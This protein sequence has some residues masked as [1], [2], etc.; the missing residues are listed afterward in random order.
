VRAY[1][2]SV[3]FQMAAIS[4]A[5]LLPLFWEE[6]GMGKGAIGSLNS[7]GMAISLVGPFFF[8]WIGSRSDP[9]R[10]VALCFFG[11]AV[12]G[13]LMLLW[14]S[15]LGQG[16]LFGASQFL[17][18]GYLTLVPVG[19]LHLLGPR[20]GLDYGRYRRVGSTGFAVAVA[21]TGFLL[22]RLGNETILWASA[23]CALLAGLP[24]VNTIRIPTPR[25][26]GDSYT[27]VM[28]NA[29]IRWFLF[30]SLVLGTWQAAP[31]VFLQ[32]RMKE[33]GAATGLIGLVLAEGGI[34]A[35]LSLTAVGRFADRF[36]VEKL[37]YI[38]A[39]AACVRLLLY[40]APSQNPYWFIAIQLLHIPVWVLSEV[41]QVKII[42]TFA[43][44]SQFARVQALLQ[45]VNTAGWA[46]AAAVTGW[47]AEACS[48]RAAFAWTA[49]LP[50]LAL[51]FLIRAHHSGQKPD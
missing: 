51:P 7:L 3:F 28:R 18:V 12:L 33:M 16:I 24:F 26:T 29:K 30:G 42:R 25:A 46:L 4:I 20:A 38:P 23:L 21:G 15:P 19:V 5:N 14:T 31:F 27:S 47:I 40:A 36:A 50:L 43:P 22:A 49:W 48:L 45:I 9:A 8:G 17:K 1:Q 13:P 10:L 34:V 39:I 2:I 35:M 32:L 6:L 37:Y 44:P 11:T 41:C